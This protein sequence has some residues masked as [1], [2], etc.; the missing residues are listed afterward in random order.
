[1]NDT[2]LE[3]N[4]L[5][6]FNLLDLPDEIIYLIVYF[7]G[8]WRFQLAST[9]KYLQYFAR[10]K[11]PVP[12]YL[13]YSPALFS[14]NHDN[15]DNYRMIK[16]KIIFI[17]LA[18]EKKRNI[19]RGVVEFTFC[20]E[21]PRIYN[22]KNRYII[23]RVKNSNNNEFF[24]DYNYDN[25]IHLI[26]LLMREATYEQLVNFASKNTPQNII[27]S[28]F[29]IEMSEYLFA[30]PNFDNLD[31]AKF[32]IE[33]CERETFLRGNFM[34]VKMLNYFIDYFRANFNPQSKMIVNNKFVFFKGRNCYVDLFNCLVLDILD[35][36]KMLMRNY[37]LDL[38][39]NFFK[40]TTDMI[41]TA[42]MFRAEKCFLFLLENNCRFKFDEFIPFVIL[43]GTDKMFEMS[44]NYQVTSIYKLVINIVINKMPKPD[45]NIYDRLLRCGA[46]K[47]DIDEIIKYKNMLRTRYDLD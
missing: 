34:N 19:S 16:D 4:D 33:R 11:F 3:T 5:V 23:G 43:Y 6:V 40:I 18:Q 10:L 9:C 17:Y 36:F 42:I 2:G 7:C 35:D 28:N 25:N 31:Y 44:L 27:A 26:W 38:A 30:D 14:L 20:D 21:K 29:M 13:K 12:G 47:N 22:D 41:M 32:Y 45:E 15:I 24:R 37:N 1:M 39:S 8:L 46:K